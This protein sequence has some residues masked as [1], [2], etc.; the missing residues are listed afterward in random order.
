MFAGRPIGV[1]EVVGKEGDATFSTIDERLLR[2]RCSQMQPL[3]ISLRDA[4]RLTGV[5][6]HSTCMVYTPRQIRDDVIHKAAVATSFI[7]NSSPVHA[8]T[9]SSTPVLKPSQQLKSSVSLIT[10]GD[11]DSGSP[12]ATVGV[13]APSKVPPSSGIRVLRCLVADDSKP[14]RK[15][16]T[17]ML[18]KRLGHTVVEAEDGAEACRLVEEAMLTFTSFDIV[19]LD[20]EMPG[21]DGPTAA[22]QIVAMGFRGK[23]VGFTGLLDADTDSFLLYGV[24]TILEKP[25]NLPVLQQLLSGK[26]PPST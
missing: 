26:H 17:H 8:V 15:V 2:E 7:G 18:E 14:S 9:A 16:L 11:A 23:I 22:R 1:V 20:C 24:T 12:N 25:L 3:V 4:M 5:I 19:F 6:K 21:M 10:E 13:L